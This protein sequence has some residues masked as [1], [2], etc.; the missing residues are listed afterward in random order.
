[1]HHDGGTMNNEYYYVAR[2]KNRFTKKLFYVGDGL[3]T[4]ASVKEVRQ[5]IGAAKGIPQKNVSVTLRKKNV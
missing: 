1:M 3:L 2:R 4:A 5:T